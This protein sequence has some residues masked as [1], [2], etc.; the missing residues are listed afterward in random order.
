M[1]IDEI[2]KLAL[3][4]M[5]QTGHQYIRTEHLFFALFDLPIELQP[6][7]IRNIPKV[8]IECEI[9]TVRRPTCN[10]EVSG[11]PSASAKRIIAN[12]QQNAIGT[13]LTPED[14]LTILIEQSPTVKRMWAKLN[15]TQVTNTGSNEV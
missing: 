14:L 8:A 7:A 10:A 5:E 9:N 12:A 4:V 6:L 13:E 1:I 2:C 11:T 15:V 3:S